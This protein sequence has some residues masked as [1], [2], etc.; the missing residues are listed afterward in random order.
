MKKAFITGVTGKKK[1][2]FIG[3]ILL[4]AILLVGC[5]LLNGV[6]T[7]KE[8]RTAEYYV[9]KYGGNIE[10]HM[11][12]LSSSDCEFLYEKFSW[13]HSLTEINEAG[14]V[15]HKIGLAYMIS[16]G[17]TAEILECEWWR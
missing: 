17:D 16:S 7:P 14:S 13:A 15:G 5:R 2:R 6:E 10:F 8:V 3:G 1:Q 9:E 11:Y 4:L 12:I